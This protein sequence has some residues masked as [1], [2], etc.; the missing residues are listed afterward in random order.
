MP[1][2]DQ[3]RAHCGRDVEIGKARLDGGISVGVVRLG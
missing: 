3:V 1:A 2:L